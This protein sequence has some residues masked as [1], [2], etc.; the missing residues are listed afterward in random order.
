MR[1]SEQD[2]ED[3]K[4]ARIAWAHWQKTADITK[5]VFIDESS[6][7]TN[8]RKLYGRSKRDVRC[9]GSAPGAWKTSTMISSLRLDGSTQC[10]VFDGAIDKPTF[11]GYMKEA[12]LP[13][14]SVGDIVILDNLSSHKD[15]E[16]IEY[17]K[18]RGITLLFLPAY[19]PDLNPIEKM[20]SKVKGILREIAAEDSG[21]LFEAI[22]VAFT[23][24]TSENAKGWFESC[25]YFQF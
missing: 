2:R 19:S 17:Y 23:R 6:A 16:T 3:I 20:W 7:K 15:K 9:H 12:L 14:L 18:L 8:M 11:R 4:A 22:R 13:A 25:G 21:S 5:L 24:I 1:A 10:I